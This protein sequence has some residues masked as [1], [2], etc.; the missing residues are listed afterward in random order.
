MPKIILETGQVESQRG[1]YGDDWQSNDNI[2]TQRHTGCISQPYNPFGHTKQDMLSL[3]CLLLHADVNRWWCFLSIDNNEPQYGHFTGGYFHNI[4][5]MFNMHV[6][7]K[8]KNKH[9]TIPDF[10]LMKGRLKKFDWSQIHRNTQMNYI[11]KNLI[12]FSFE[13]FYYH[14]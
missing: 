8:K 12:W 3:L 11:I 9:V 7:I 10:L 13:L 2:Q 6:Q 14:L 1:N 5:L 4:N